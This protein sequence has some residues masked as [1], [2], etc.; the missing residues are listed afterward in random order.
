MVAIIFSDIDGTLI[1]SDLQVTDM[2]RQSI[3]RAVQAG[4]VFVPVSARMPEAIKPI[5]DGIGIESPIISYNG[6]LIQNQSKEVIASHPMQ[7]QIALDICHFVQEKYPTIVWNIYSFH[8]WYAIDRK[9]WWIVR[10][11]QIVNVQSK[12]AKLSELQELEAV[13]KVLL[14]GDSSVIGPLEN[15]LKQVFPELS[16]AKSSPS[17][18][19]IVAQGIEK[20]LAVKI[21]AEYMGISLEETIAF[22]DNFNDLSMLQTVGKGFVM[23]NGPKEVQKAIG[24][25]TADHNHDGIAKVL[26]EYL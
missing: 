16:I 4:K 21:F 22:G 13:H 9:D 3:Q 1:N 10:E 2:T 25:V 18:I 12:E 11:E 17:F 8:D 23:G 14:M 15:H 24:N 20:G 6:A 26:A 7:T 19:E 5:I